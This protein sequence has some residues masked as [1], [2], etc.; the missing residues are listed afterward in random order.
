MVELQK[1]AAQHELVTT[2]PG[3]MEYVMKIFEDQ[4]NLGE[5]KYCSDAEIDDMVRWALATKNSIK[6]ENSITEDSLKESYSKEYAKVSETINYYKEQFV[7]SDVCI[8]LS[9]SQNEKVDKCNNT[10]AIII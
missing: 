4:V 8:E 1:R 5:R 7:Q 6:I 2:T 10:F 9:N 3:L